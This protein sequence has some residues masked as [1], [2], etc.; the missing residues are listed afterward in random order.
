MKYVLA[1]CLFT[2]SSIASADALHLVCLGAGSTNRV[3]STSVYGHVNGDSAWA[4]ALSSRSVGFDDQVDIEI[5]EGGQSKIRLPRAMLPPLRG[6]KDGWF[7]LDSVKI[8]DAAITG[9]AQVNVIN[10]PKVRLDR[11]TG[12]ISINGKAGD[13]SGECRK[14]DPAAIE[15]KF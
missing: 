6:G 15:R 1:A 13:Y 5:N 3:A 14:F 2:C 10:S 7:E 12:R 4:Q 11:M 9:T 8:T